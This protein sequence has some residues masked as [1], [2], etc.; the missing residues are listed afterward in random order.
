[1]N[2]DKLINEAF[3][4]ELMKSGVWDIAR[5]DRGSRT[6]EA[7]IE[8]D[9]KKGYGEGAPGGSDLAMKIANKL[10]RK[11]EE[12][13]EDEDDKKSKKD[14]KKSKKDEKKSKKDDKDEEEVT[15][16]STEPTAES[17]ALELLENLSEEVIL[18]FVNL[19]HGA[20][21]TEAEEVE[22][23]EAIL[24][25]IEASVTSINEEYDTSEADEETM[26][27]AIVENLDVEGLDDFTPEQIMEAI[28]AY[29]AAQ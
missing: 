18:E 11:S 4:D 23:D 12:D 10:K 9:E 15:E 25:A 7:V 22:I 21:L 3:V 17:L 1:M 13:D 6:D 16:E 27:D 8:E 14:D 26:I 5:V 24:N 28:I 2:T 19:L 20:L 29:V